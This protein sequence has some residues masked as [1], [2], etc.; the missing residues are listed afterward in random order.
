MDISSQRKS[1]SDSNSCTIQVLRMSP[2]QYEVMYHIICPFGGYDIPV[3]HQVDAQALN[4]GMNLKVG[5]G[6]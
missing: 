5:D 6:L 2:A 4:S 3:V 1:I